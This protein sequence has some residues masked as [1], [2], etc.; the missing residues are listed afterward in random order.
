VE[1]LEMLYRIL[2]IAAV[3]VT[4]LALTGCPKPADD[5][6]STTTTTT[7]DGDTTSTTES[8]TE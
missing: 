1:D 7:D 2:L 8:T 4:A 3:A 6:T 5:T